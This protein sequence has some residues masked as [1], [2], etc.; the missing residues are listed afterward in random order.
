MLLNLSIR[1]GID[2]D[3]IETWTVEK[4]R[5]YLVTLTPEKKSD[6]QTPEQ[7][8]AAFNNLHGKS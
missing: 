7:M 5:D 8:A 2:V 6:D 3:V 4:I 1:L